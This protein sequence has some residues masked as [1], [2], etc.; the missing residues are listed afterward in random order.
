MST[1]DPRSVAAYDQLT[2]FFD[3]RI[4]LSLDRITL[5][6][7]EGLSAED[8]FAIATG[9][10]YEFTTE[11]SVLAALAA[12]ILVRMAEERVSHD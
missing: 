6:L 12:L 5:G 2:A 9:A 4:T 10:F 3:P 11:P 7:Q 8:C 1:I